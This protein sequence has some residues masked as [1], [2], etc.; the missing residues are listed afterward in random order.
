MKLLS[1]KGFYY[2]V[3]RRK[4]FEFIVL[5]VFLLFF[6]LPLLNLFMLAFAD[7]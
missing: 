2:A 1:P 4:F 6:Y 3:G 5:S 7:K